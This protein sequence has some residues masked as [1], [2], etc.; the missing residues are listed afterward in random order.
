MEAV[1]RS[2]WDYYLSYAGEE[3]DTFAGQ[4]IQRF[5]DEELPDMYMHN[6]TA[7]YDWET[8]PDHLWNHELTIAREKGRDFLN[9]FTWSSNPGL[10]PVIADKGAEA[11]HYVYMKGMVG[12]LNSGS[13]TQTGGRVERASSPES[14]ADYEA[15]D[16]KVNGP[17][18][19]VDFCR[20][21][22]RYKSRIFAREK[23]LNLYLGY[24]D[25]QIAGVCEWFYHPPTGLV[26]IEDFTVDPAVRSRGLGTIMLDRMVRDAAAA[27]AKEVYLITEADNVPAQRLYARFGLKQMNLGHT[28]WFMKLQV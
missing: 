13:G 3:T 20:R 15:F 16:V 5:R 8:D 25:G 26:K 23:E 10:E 18:F 1:I 22:S 21:R 6:F 19:G 14:F 2:D 12:D 17:N 27:G 11:S 28:S 4:S 7:V 9:L 24:L